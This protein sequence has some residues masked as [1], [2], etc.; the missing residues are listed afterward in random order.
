MH[1]PTA[2]DDS[3]RL[4]EPDQSW[5]RSQTS[6]SRD[7]SIN[8]EPLDSRS[9]GVP[10]VSPIITPIKFGG[11]LQEGETVGPPALKKPKM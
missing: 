8:L 3:T 11:Y 6:D 9:E 5:W 1:T 4:T 7:Y 2:T 10:R